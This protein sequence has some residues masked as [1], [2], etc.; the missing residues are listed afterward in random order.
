M[1]HTNRYELLDRR[2]STPS[3]L[4]GAP[5]PSEQ[6]LQRMLHAALRVPDHGK[7]TPWRVLAI[8]GD[9]RLALGELLVQRQLEL[10]PHAS[11]AV[12]DKDRQRFA[13]APIVLA[14]IASV[15]HGDRIP[16]QEQL[17]SGGCVCFALLLA[18]EAEG[19]G[20]QWL[21]GWAAYDPVI[22][23]RLGLSADERVLGFIHI[24]TATERAPERVRPTVADKLSEWRPD[25]HR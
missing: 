3:R 5:G 15:R 9:A 2:I 10:D 12:I 19:F 18:A 22:T 23:G 8:R 6:Q 7:L 1:Q 20:A 21:T 24:G 11:A 14:V 4:L 25:A 16:E 13:C 17:L